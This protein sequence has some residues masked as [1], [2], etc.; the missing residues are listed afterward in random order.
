M[1][2]LISVLR[3]IAHF[4]MRGCRRDRGV[5]ITLTPC[6][7]WP[8]TSDFLTLR[9]HAERHI[10]GQCAAGRGHGDVAGGCAF[11]YGRSYVFI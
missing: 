2:G 6:A 5:E 7:A 4:A 1:Q 11:G 3:Y 10:A 9:D 8:W